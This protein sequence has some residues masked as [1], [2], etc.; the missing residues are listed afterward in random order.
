MRLIGGKRNFVGVYKGLPEFYRT[1]QRHRKRRHV[2]HSDV[3]FPDPWKERPSCHISII[4]FSSC[5]FDSN[6][7]LLNNIESQER[8]FSN[9][10]EIRKLT[11]QMNLE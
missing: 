10:L 1:S 5:V 4:W 3:L 9:F 6:V 2:R 8:Y 11:L 7:L